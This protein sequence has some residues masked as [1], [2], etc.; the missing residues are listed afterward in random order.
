MRQHYT[1]KNYA[2]K[3]FVRAFLNA[4]A[5]SFF[6]I[7]RGISLGANVIPCEVRAESKHLV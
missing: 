7:L 1:H 5:A 6:R 2:K 4:P 3:Y